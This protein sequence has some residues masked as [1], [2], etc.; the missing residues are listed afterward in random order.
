MIISS[1]TQSKTSDFAYLASIF[2]RKKLGKIMFLPV[3]ECVTAYLYS[4]EESKA[5]QNG[6]D[7]PHRIARIYSCKEQGVHIGSKTIQ[8]ANYCLALLVGRITQNSKH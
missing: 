7:I 5:E 3:R 8:G 1:T 2:L 4:W 6:W